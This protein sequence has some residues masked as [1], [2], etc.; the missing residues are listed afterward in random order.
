[1]QKCDN[2]NKLKKKENKKKIDFRELNR[3]VC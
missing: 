2:P 3:S 1:M